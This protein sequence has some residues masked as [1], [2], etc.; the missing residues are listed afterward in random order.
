MLGLALRAGSPILLDLPLGMFSLLAGQSSKY[1]FSVC[2]DGGRDGESLANTSVNSSTP[3]RSGIKEHRFSSEGAALV[4]LT[5]RTGIT[6]L[7]PEAAFQLFDVP[8][9][10]SLFSGAC[11]YSCITAAQLYRC[12]S[13]DDN[14]SMDDPHILVCLS[15]SNACTATFF[16]EI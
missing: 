3:L 16:W 13:Y 10:Q 7:F 9:L 14:L 8:Q 2:T 15:H 5:M 12:T 11:E 4:A 6:S 1:L